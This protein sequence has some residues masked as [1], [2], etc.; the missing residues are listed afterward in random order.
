MNAQPSGAAPDDALKIKNL[1]REAVRGHETILDIAPPTEDGKPTQVTF[2]VRPLPAPEPELAASPARAHDFAEA[3]GFAAWLKRQHQAETTE[4]RAPLSVLA[5]PVAGVIYAVLDDSDATFGGREVVTL[6]PV[7]HPRW[8]PWAEILGRRLD[9]ETFALF[10]AEHRRDVAGAA[11]RDLALTLSQVRASV[12][13]T[14]DRGRGRK[15]VNGIVVTTEVTGQRGEER[16]E[17]PDTINVSLPIFVA[18]APQT[19][20]LDLTVEAGRDGAVTALLSGGA[21][22]EA[23]HG[24]FEEMLEVVRKVV[25]PLGAVVTF[26]SPGDRPWAYLPGAKS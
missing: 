13:T 19:I 24:A 25:A 4:S 2:S 8:K 17:L 3:E 18:T 23:R 22:E 10:V 26:G 12:K 11:G 15:A 1:L 14:V 9:M 7:M 21:A 5:D 16:V 6:R 20:E